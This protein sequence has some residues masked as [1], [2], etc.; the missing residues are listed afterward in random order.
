MALTGLLASLGGVAGLVS[1]DRITSGVAE[2]LTD[3][4]VI[5]GRVARAIV[6]LRDHPA[7]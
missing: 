7:L 2:G 5:A 6:P 3:D 1:D 4:V